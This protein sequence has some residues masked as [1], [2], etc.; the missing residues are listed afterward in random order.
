[1]ENTMMKNIQ[2]QLKFQEEE[3]DRMDDEEIDDQEL[4]DGIDAQII[5]N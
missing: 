1:M 5:Y 3:E 4:E 2:Q